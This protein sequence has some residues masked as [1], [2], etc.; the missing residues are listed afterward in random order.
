MPG[1]LDDVV[2]LEFAT[3]VSGP[4]TG[5]L[6]ADLGAQVIKV[7]P[8][9]G[10][11]MRGESPLVDGT[12]AF[13][14]WLNLNKF[15]IV[16]E[17][18]DAALLEL[19][20][21]A[22]IVLHSLR[23]NAADQF[24]LAI[25]AAN[26]SS[27]IVSFSPYG[28][29]GP[30]ADWSASPLTEWA[31][32]GFHYIAGDPAREPLPLP[33]YQAEFHSG[34]HA[35]SAALAAM[36][37]ARKTGE[38][39]RIEMSHQEAT[40]SDHAWLTTSWTHQ[41]KIQSRTGSVYAPCS[42]GY[43]YIFNLVP[44]PNLF[45]LME[46]FDLLEDEELLAPLNWQARF[47]TDVLPAFAEWTS[48]RTKQEV[49]HAC[50]ELRVAA[51]PVN[52]MKDVAE[53]SQ[54]A[55]R[56]WFIEMPVAGRAVQAPG[57]PYLLSETPCAVVR[58]APALGEHQGEVVAAG[59]AWA[60]AK[61]VRRNEAVEPGQPPL[62]G[63]R[64]LEVTANWAGPAAG[65]QL[66]DLGADV[67]KIELATKPATRSLMSIPEDLWPDHYNRSGYFNKLNRNKRDV[68]LNLSTAEGKALFLRLVA[69]SDVV[70]ENNAARV[71]GN[72]GLGYDTLSAANPAL[73]MCSMSGFGATG[74]ERNYSAY[75]SNIETTSGLSSLL[76]YGPGEYF[77]TGSFYADPV[78]G[79]HGA[80]AILAALHHRR[81]TGL[82]QWIDMSLLE[83]VTPF[84]S[85]QLLDYTVTGEVA[86][87]RANDAWGNL[88]EG[89]VACA[90]RDCWLAVT[91]RDARELSR[92]QDVLGI[93]ALSPADTWAALRAWAIERDHDS[94]ANDLQAAGIA[95]A[96]VMQN[97]EIVTDNH[98][99]D[100]GFFV[101]ARHPV[102]GTFPYPGWPWRL[103]R[104][105]AK[106]RKAAPTFAESNDEVFGGMLGLSQEEQDALYATGVSAR[107]PSFAAGSL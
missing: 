96:P 62:T 89:V 82:G 102:A 77:G 12:S 95:A 59:F 67:L 11:P 20:R 90:G 98:L 81:R 21:H 8:P 56:D 68:C 39:Q 44:Y 33:G 13:F 105:P 45:I 28:R 46:R 66:A 69:M 35:A 57:F 88:L 71:M 70:I 34:L 83:A 41:G 79:N 17:P 48:T 10:D 16:A 104:T 14:A 50:Q 5:K 27:V 84:F 23:G 60:N 1:A 51:S 31:T 99:N 87:P 103:E 25:S 101:P 86:E 4:Y 22:D 54:L 43:V 91:I 64:V 3:G 106:F 38:G 78:T 29:S 58:P 42:D 80:V 93:G 53:N 2:V 72:L 49:Y 26:P 55:S 19:A 9:A 100:R 74:S 94:S 75:G 18:G 52:T 32:S 37:H 61:T 15:G 63:L 73:V 7:E 36:E 40:L 85:Q 65:R 6:L 30:R 92:L 24:E 47:A 76:G 107:E 97:W